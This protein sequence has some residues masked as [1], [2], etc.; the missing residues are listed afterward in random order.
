VSSN[1]TLGTTTELSE[2]GTFSLQGLNTLK[3][4]NYN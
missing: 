2:Y 3:D 4:S 1:L